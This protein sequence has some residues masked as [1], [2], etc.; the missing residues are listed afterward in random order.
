MSLL[1]SVA[2]SLSSTVNIESC[3]QY[4]AETLIPT[5]VQVLLSKLRVLQ[6]ACRAL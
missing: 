5:G 4:R 2:Y 1:A 3:G 6:A